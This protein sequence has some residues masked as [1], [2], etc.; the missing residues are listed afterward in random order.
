MDFRHALQIFNILYENIN[1][2][3]LSARGKADIGSADKT[4]TYGEISPEAF[5]SILHEPAV[6]KKGVFYD[7]G[8]GTG[9]AVIL[10]YLL[11]NYSSCVGIE[12]L[13]P[14]HDEASAILH[15]FRHEFPTL[16]SNKRPIKLVHDDF[17]DYDFSDAAVVF[18][19]S[20]CFTDELWEELVKKFELLKPGTVVI[21][22]T[23][24]I[25]SIFFEQL[26]SKEYGM[27]WGRATVHIYKR[28]KS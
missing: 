1:G 28:L 9:K 15:K 6:P 23:R 19:H 18:T 13:K 12:F 3:L 5:K 24:T 22:V 14:L 20:T 26:K 25:N 4:F 21:T 11:T 17:L 10:A 2:Y 27:A 8:S 16:Y 7:L